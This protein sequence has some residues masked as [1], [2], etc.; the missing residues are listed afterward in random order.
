MA[1]NGAQRKLISMLGGFRFCPEADLA[2]VVSIGW[3]ETDSER[4]IPPTLRRPL[5]AENG[6][7]TAVL[8]PPPTKA[9]SLVLSRA[10]CL[11][12][13]LAKH[14]RSVT[15]ITPAQPVGSEESD[16]P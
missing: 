14:P 4:A 10:G 12:N 9:L 15:L 13:Y 3:V 11:R 1:G 2:N 5:A 16:A 8:D 7:N 6:A